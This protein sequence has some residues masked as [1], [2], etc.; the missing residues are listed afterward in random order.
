MNRRFK[1]LI[2]VIF[3]FVVIAL[4][5]SWLSYAFFGRPKEIHEGSVVEI[6]LRETMRELPPES[7]VAQ[8]LDPSPNLWDL[9]R[10]FQMAAQDK[11]VKAVYL[12]IPALVISWGQTEELRDL[13]AEFRKSK[14]PVHA[15]LV[16]DIPGELEIYLASAAD[17][18]TM[19][20][21]SGL[22][23]NGLLAE[24]TFYKKTLEKLYVQPEFIQMKEYKSAETYSRESMTPEIRSM[25]E[26]LLKDVQG[27]FVASV[28]RERKIAPDRLLQLMAKGTATASV[29][30]K[31]NLVDRL[32]YKDEIE[33]KLSHRT[34]NGESKYLGI[35]A[36]DYL[37]SAQRSFK[38]RSEYKV[39]VVGG[40]GTIIAGETEPLFGTLGGVRTATQ[41]RQLREDKEIKGVILRVDSPGGSAV[42]SDMIWREVD[43]LEK[44]GKPVIVSMSGVAGSG[45]YYI[46]MAAR[47]IV[48]QP[49][50]I[51]GS[52]GVIFGKFNIRGFYEWLGMSIDEV[53]LMPNADIFSAFNSLDEDQQAQIKSWME[54]IYDNFVRKAAVGR[55]T[56]YATL[57]PKAHGKIYTGAQ[58]K[59]LGLVDLIGG[60][61]TAVGEMKKF[62]KVP[63]DKELELIIYPR[64]KNLLQIL[65]EGNLIFS[66]PINLTGWLK[67]QMGVLSRPAPWLLT[68]LFRIY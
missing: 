68:P 17:S 47:R 46:S 63:A 25:Y 56:S 38:T 8:M 12:E 39:A 43:L 5:L 11:R 15:M 41:L 57:E 53:K 36:Q 33:Q 30:L 32:G 6:A 7:P 24:V 49:S 42:A 35:P 65:L 51:T 23:V 50:T 21:D 4:L 62:L 34:K 37:E 29:A 59:E 45:G 66:Q 31:E 61:Q 54:V 22:L 18:I 2:F 3:A 64:P 20:P 10:I 16:S 44:A 58:A 13:M 9:R 67:E 19:N 1:L 28:S 52:I 40:V 60:M 55:K 14:K 48:S 27:R 26:S